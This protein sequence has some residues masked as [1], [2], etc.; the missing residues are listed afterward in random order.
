MEVLKYRKSIE[1]EVGCRI[2]SSENIVLYRIENGLRMMKCCN[3]KL[4]FTDQ[5]Q[6]QDYNSEFN[7]WDDLGT[8]NEKEVYRQSAYKPFMVYVLEKILPKLIHRDN[9]KGL[10]IGCG[11]GTFLKVL[12]NA[13][14]KAY[15]LDSSKSIISKITQE[16]FADV[17][18]QLLTDELYED[19][20]FDMI[21][22]WNVLEHV[23]NPEEIIRLC[24]K[25]LNDGGILFV[26][27]P[28][29]AFHGPFSKIFKTDLFPNV[30]LFNFSVKSI[31]ILFNKSGFKLKTAEYLFDTKTEIVERF[32]SSENLF[33][34]RILITV[35]HAYAIFT[36]ILFYCSMKS[37]NYSPTINVII[38]K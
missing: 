14:V 17:R 32:Y 26:K 36:K 7:W 23:P 19:N 29:I 20:F 22:L 16:G 31:N 34:S 37:W 10:D 21:T 3:C 33:K 30:H 12:H 6:L 24:Y 28:N 15:G 38:T 25:K 1:S 9:L 18:G 4:I 5:S 13:E 27:V 2:C 11:A 8:V 35:K